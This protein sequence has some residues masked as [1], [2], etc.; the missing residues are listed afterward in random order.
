MVPWAGPHRTTRVSEDAGASG[1]SDR[2]FMASDHPPLPNWPLQGYL[3]TGGESPFGTQ[4]DTAPL[5]TCLCLNSMSEKS[6]HQ[7]LLLNDKEES[8]ANYL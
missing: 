6:K 5:G 7:D 2:G 8:N 4:L 3:E 1:A